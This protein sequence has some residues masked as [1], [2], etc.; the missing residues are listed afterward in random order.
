MTTSKLSQRTRQSTTVPAILKDREIREALRQ[1]LMGRTPTPVRIIEE[2]G[3]HNGNARADLVAVYKEMHCFEIK[4]ATDSIGRLVRQASFF[5]TAFPKV[6]LVTTPNHLDWCLNN[7]PS[8]W[9]ILL[10]EY[11]NENV[12]LRYVRSA[13]NSPR[14]IKQ[15][16]LMMLWKDELTS[17]AEDTAKIRVK[18]SYSREDI[19]THLSSALDKS[20][21]ISSIQNAILNRSSIQSVADVS[22]VTC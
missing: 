8:Y 16:A 7:I 17:I 10:A 22:D 19:A 15:K 5:D 20:L 14:F 3:V 18:S 6:S 11:N 9:G 2:L 4:G 21:I 12:W 13:K 1:H